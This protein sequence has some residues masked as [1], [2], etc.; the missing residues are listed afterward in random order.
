M[1]EKKPVIIHGHPALLKWEPPRAHTLNATQFT[2]LTAICDTYIPS[3]P[4]P[5]DSFPIVQGVTREDAARF[6]KL[7]ASDEDVI[8][9][10]RSTASLTIRCFLIF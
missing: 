9:N 6:F 7:K 1:E 2:A 10:V 3:L 8:D 4:P 5:G